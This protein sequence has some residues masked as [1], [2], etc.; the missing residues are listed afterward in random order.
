MRRYVRLVLISLFLPFVC[1]SQ[2]KDAFAEPQRILDSFFIVYQTEGHEAALTKLLE[3]S[4][5]ISKGDIENV[6]SKLTE[7]TNQA[8]KYNGFEKIK[9]VQYGSSVVAYTY[10]AKYDSQPLKLLFRFYKPNDKWQIQ[11]F[12]YNPDFSDELEEAS[13]GYRLKENSDN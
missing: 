13:K 8:G 11:G 9:R 3:T 12:N 6:I 2:S 1:T 5:W 7:F 10:I 4:K